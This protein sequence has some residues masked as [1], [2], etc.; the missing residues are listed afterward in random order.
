MALGTV[1]LRVCPADW[2]SSGSRLEFLQ[3]LSL[4]R[5]E[6]RRHL[7]E[8]AH[9]LIAPAA[10]IEILDTFSAQLENSTRLRALRHL[11]FD[12]AVQGRHL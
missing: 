10:A 8:D 4:S 6:L 7:H 5:V 9:K 2:P 12:L 11:I 3:Q 1:F